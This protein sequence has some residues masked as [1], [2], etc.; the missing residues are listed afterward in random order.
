MQPTPDAHF[1]KLLSQGV[2]SEEE[3]IPTLHM[4]TF[5]SAIFFAQQEAFLK[6]WSKE[7]VAFDQ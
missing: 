1:R 7:D 6:R 5:A 2:E 3:S 4:I